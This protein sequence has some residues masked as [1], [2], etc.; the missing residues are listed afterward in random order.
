MHSTLTDAPV[1]SFTTLNLR[2]TQHATGLMVKGAPLLPSRGLLSSQR[3]LAWTHTKASP[4]SGWMLKSS[5]A[6]CFSALVQSWKLRIWLF[7][8]SFQL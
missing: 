1:A 7:V 3:K 4:M 6:D 8:V 5:A 2:S